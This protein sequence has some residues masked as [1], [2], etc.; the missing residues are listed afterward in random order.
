[1]LSQGLVKDH[2]VAVF[3]V[4]TTR[5]PSRSTHTTPLDSTLRR[6]LLSLA[7]I[8]MAAPVLLTGTA[9][10]ATDAVSND[11]NPS[12]APVETSV[13]GGVAGWV[14]LDW[15]E[16][17]PESWQA[18]EL[19][20][21]PSEVDPPE[22]DT[23]AVGDVALLSA[24]KC[25]AD[26]C[27]EVEGRGTYVE[28]WNTYAFGNV[29]CTAGRYFVNGIQTYSATVCPGSTNDGVY[30]IRRNM[31]RYYAHGTKLCNRWDRIIG[32]ACADIKR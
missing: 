26:V 31:Y 17:N 8:L 23:G 7:A 30:Y 18:Q 9:A 12:G 28:R 20:T 11:A 3:Y 27:I 1:V 19:P 10:S 5:S 24:F 16:A 4:L 22:V 15:L 29:G 32:L 21:S 14:S 2:A 25:A 6:S 13:D